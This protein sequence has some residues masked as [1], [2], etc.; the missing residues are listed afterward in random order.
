MSTIQ[1]SLDDRARLGDLIAATGN[2]TPGRA[3]RWLTRTGSA[4]AAHDVAMRLVL[5]GFGAADL[6]QPLPDPDTFIARLRAA[7]ERLVKA[8]VR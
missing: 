1:R 2:D 8:A 7:A 5:L 3:I 4:N 6:D